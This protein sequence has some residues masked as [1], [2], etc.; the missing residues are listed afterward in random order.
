MAIPASPSNLQLG[1]HPSL[2]ATISRSFCEQLRC[3]NAIFKRDMTDEE[4]L[5]RGLTRRQMDQA[6]AAHCVP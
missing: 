1:F 2:C 3:K 6:F 4:L 5:K